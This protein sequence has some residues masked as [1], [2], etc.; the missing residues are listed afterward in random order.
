MFAFPPIPLRLIGIISLVVVITG[1]YLRIQFLENKLDSTQLDNAILQSTLNEQVKRCS[2][3]IS[4]V[5]QLEQEKQN[6]EQTF[7]SVNNELESYKK[8]R[9]ANACP[10]QIENVVYS[11]ALDPDLARVL[12]LSDCKA[13]GKQCGDTK[14]SETRVRHTYTVE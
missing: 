1:G 2:N 14:A 6:I 13:S 11:D 4:A 7:S 10:K 3:I 5:D 12:N 8:K 9:A